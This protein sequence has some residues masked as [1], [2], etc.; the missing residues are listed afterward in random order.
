MKKRKQR[1]N[2]STGTRSKP[3]L[4]A[5]QGARPWA[6]DE[7]SNS[8]EIDPLELVIRTAEAERRRRLRAFDRRTRQERNVQALG[9]WKGKRAPTALRILADG[10][11]WFDFPFGGRRLRR[12]DVIARLQ[13]LIPYPILNQAVRGDEVRH[14]LGVRRRQRLTELLHDHERDFNVLLFSGGGNDVVGDP[15]CLWLAEHDAV[16][17]D[18]N[19]AINEPV[20]S[21]VLAVLRVAYEELLRIRD[22][23]QRVRNGRRIV[24]FFHDYDL[25]LPTGKGVCR[26]GPWLRPSLDFR[27]WVANPA[28][29]QIVHAL[30]RRFS[31]MLQEIASSATDVRVIRTQGTLSPGDWNDELHPNRAGFGKIAA[32]FRDAL[33]SEYPEHFAESK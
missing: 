6:P 2:S 17:G 10:D 20:F 26:F 25:A 12:G 21:H 3:R 23:A 31:S 11:S 15:L 30:L 9:F 32:R 33:T 28:A 4:A 22:K 5:A 24:V 29:T 14:I 27:G 16:G 8:R 18:P 1:R 13:E 19:R 7:A